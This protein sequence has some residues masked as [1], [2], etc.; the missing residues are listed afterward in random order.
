MIITHKLL[1]LGEPGAG[2][3]TCI[4]AVSD[5][6]PITTDVACTDELANLKETTTVAFDY[7][8]LSIGEKGTLRLYG[9]PGQSRFRF[10]FDVVR[11][12]LLGIV[13]LV[14]A[15]SEHGIRGLEE[16][17][18]LYAEEIRKR[19]SVIAINKNQ[20]PTPELKAACQGLLRRHQLVMPIV[21]VDA[22][23]REDII[24]LFELLFLLLEHGSDCMDLETPQSWS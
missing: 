2:K 11:D 12:G 17:L 22:R 20:S 23:K 13:I 1:F 3:T 4:T 8:E 24:R 21:T 6:V 5:I 10:M 7:G 19:P 15:S 9:L 18:E 14:D 16:T